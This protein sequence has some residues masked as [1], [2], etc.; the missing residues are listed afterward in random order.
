MHPLYDVFHHR[1][2][3][4]FIPDKQTFHVTI[5]QQWENVEYVC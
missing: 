1:Y 2:S 3:K 4:S 5:Q